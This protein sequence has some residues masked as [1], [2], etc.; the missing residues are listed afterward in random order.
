MP[1]L[2]S[3]RGKGNALFSS[4][5]KEQKDGGDKKKKAADS[6]RGA[7]TGAARALFR[8]KNKDK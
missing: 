5:D 3:I 8:P 7:Q 6:E 1:V 4:K 2:N